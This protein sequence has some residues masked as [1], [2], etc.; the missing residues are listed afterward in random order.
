MFRFALV[1]PDLEK[2]PATDLDVVAVPLPP[3]EHNPFLRMGQLPAFLQTLRKG[4][5]RQQ[6]TLAIRLL[7][8]TGVRT[9]E[10]RSATPDQFDLDLGVWNI[11]PIAVKQLKNKMRKERRRPDDMPS[12]V[13]PLSEQ[14]REIVRF[15][16]ARVKAAPHL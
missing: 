7:L 14:A 13:V 4:P 12:Y 6:T 1:V 11:P 3:V 15:L 8:L 10:L 16:L 5:I 2:N 9:G